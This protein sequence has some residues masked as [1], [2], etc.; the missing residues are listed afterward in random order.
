MPGLRRVK[1]LPNSL[2]FFYVALISFV[3][4]EP[5]RPSHLQM[6]SHLPN[7]ALRFKVPRES[8]GGYRHSNHS[9]FFHRIS[10]THEIKTH[11]SFATPPCKMSGNHSSQA[12]F[13]LPN[14]STH[15]L[16]CKGHLLHGHICF[17]FA[18]PQAFISGAQSLGELQSPLVN[19]PFDSHPS[20]LGSQLRLTS[21]LD[22]SSLL[23]PSGTRI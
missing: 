6:T 13:T 8:E 14:L 22:F 23:Q 7:A 5:S 17:C 21:T 4:E 15:V 9:S 10:T 12:P 1:I 3:R 20:A 11:G 19:M 16:P 2:Q 18:E